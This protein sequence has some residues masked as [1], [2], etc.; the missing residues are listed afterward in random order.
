[1]C[2]PHKGYLECWKVTKASASKAIYSPAYLTVDPLPGLM[3][4][5]PRSIEQVWEL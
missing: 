1:L 4:V 3:I 5:A 2:Q